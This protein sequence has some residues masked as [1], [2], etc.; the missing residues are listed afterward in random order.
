M[1]ISQDRQIP[2]FEGFGGLCRELN[3]Y[4]G[5]KDYVILV[6]KC[7]KDIYDC[8]N[9]H[10]LAEALGITIKGIAPASIEDPIVKSGQSESI[11]GARVQI[12]ATAYERNAANR[13]K[14]LSK[15]GTTCQICGFDA[16]EIYG[17]EFAGWI[18]VHHIVPLSEVGQ[19][20]SVNPETDLIPVCPNC[21]MILHAKKGGTYTPEEVKNMLKK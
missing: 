3:V 21:H 9:W 4:Q 18:H 2:D 8:E 13:A 11:E 7:F 6:Y 16:A 10:I 14:C 19:A 1:V 12:T 20:H 15:Y 17:E 5:N